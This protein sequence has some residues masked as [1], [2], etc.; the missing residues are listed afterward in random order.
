ML[1][2]MMAELE[3]SQTDNKKLKGEVSNARKI[4]AENIQ[5]EGGQGNPEAIN[6]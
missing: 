4:D 2:Q 5:S 6:V 1:K 3:R